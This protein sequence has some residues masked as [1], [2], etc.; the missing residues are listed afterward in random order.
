MGPQAEWQLW[1]SNLQFADLQVGTSIVV[2]CDEFR[3]PALY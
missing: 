3:M 1:T 2:T